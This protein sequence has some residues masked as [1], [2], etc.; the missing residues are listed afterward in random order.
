MPM[1]AADLVDLE[2]DAA[3]EAL[4]A[5]RGAC[6]RQGVPLLLSAH[7][8]DRTPPVAQMVAAFRRA[9]DLGAD[10]AKLAV[11]PTV[12]GDVDALM[13]ATAQA[14]AKAKPGEA[15]PKADTKPASAPAPASKP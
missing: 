8:F 10:I 6:R 2:T 4:L 9:A 7:H 5:L 14:D 13:A 12:P 1:S 15:R 11:M 3:P